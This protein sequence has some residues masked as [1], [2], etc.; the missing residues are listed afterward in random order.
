MYLSDSFLIPLIYLPSIS[1]SSRAAMKM[2]NMDAVF[3]FMFS[4]PR[5]KDKVCWIV[6]QVINL[7][8]PE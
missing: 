1:N 8:I 4:C 7:D 3:E 6:I 5:T 2:A